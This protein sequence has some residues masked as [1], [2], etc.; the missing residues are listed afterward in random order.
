MLKY[1]MPFMFAFIYSCSSMSSDWSAWKVKDVSQAKQTWRFCH[2]ELDG[3]T[4]HRKGM[5]Y[6]SQ[7]CRTKNPWYSG[8]KVECRSLPLFCAWG[9]I[10]C[11]D[12]NAIFNK[13]ITD[14]EKLK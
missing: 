6:I 7:E 2:Q 10:D 3:P 12:K 4:Y 11:M 5:C 9:D 14:K 1:I 13:V 8:E